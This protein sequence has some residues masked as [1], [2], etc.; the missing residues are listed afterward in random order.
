[1]IVV[2]YENQLVEWAL[3]GP[4]ARWER[5]HRR[6]AAPAKPVI[7]YPRPTVFSAHPLIVVKETAAPLVD[8]LMSADVQQIAWTRHGFRG[9][10][11]LSGDTG[12]PLVASRIMA[13]VDAVLPMPDIRTMLSL[14]GRIGG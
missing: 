2:G 9:P 3:A 13:R 14:I 6:A 4:E 11:G 7:L 12:N 5:R 10:L 1:M 8:A